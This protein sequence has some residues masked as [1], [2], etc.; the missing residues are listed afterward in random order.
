MSSYYDLLGVDTLATEKDIRKAYRFKAKLLHPDVNPSPDAQLKFQMLLTAYE[1]LI[2]KNK[3]YYY[4]NKLHSS[5]EQRQNDYN[6]YAKYYQQSYYNEWQKIQKERKAYEA[7]LKHEEF[8]KNRLRFRSSALYYPFYALLYFALVFC[9]LFGVTVLA[10]CGYLIYEIHFTF[11]FLLSPF[12]CGGIY[13]I[14]C[15]GDWY[16]SAKRYF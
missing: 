3:R 6:R 7:K 2:D 8:L 5:Y 16:K 9:Y 15:T 11:I 12:I 10:I 13:F 14:K 4:D 1:T